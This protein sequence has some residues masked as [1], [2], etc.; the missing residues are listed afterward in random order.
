MNKLELIQAVKD[1]TGLNK[2]E[3]SEVVKLFFDS[4]TETM[5]KG[6]RIEIRGLWSFFIKEYSGYTGRKPLKQGIRFKYQ[7]NDYPFSSQVKS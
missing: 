3:A 6:E 1:K 7:P 5:V 2:Q 4:L